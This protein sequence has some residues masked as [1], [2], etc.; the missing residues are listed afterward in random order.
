MRRFCSRGLG[1]VVA[2]ISFWGL[3]ACGGHKPAGQST[4]PAKVNLT[5]AGST[6]VQLGGF[7]NFV[8]SAQ[9]ATGTNVNTVFTFTSSDTSILNIAPNGA[10]CAGVWNASFTTCTPAGTGVVQVQASTRNVFSP[11]TYVFVHPQIDHVE[12]VGVLPDGLPIQEPCLSQGQA[13]T[14]EAHAFSQGT[15]ITSAVGP[16]TWAAKDVSVVGLVPKVNPA[17]NFATNQAVATANMPGLTQIY[18]TASGVASD[19][20]QQPNLVPSPPVIFDFF[21]TC[22]IQNIT[23]ELGTAGSRQTQFAVTKGTSE[24]AIAT[25][26]DVLGNSSLP[27]I[28]NGVVLSK[29][30]LT[31]TSSQPAVIQVAAACV[32]SCAISTPSPGAGAVTAACSPPSC[33]IGFPQVPAAFSPP[34][35]A[36]CATYVHSLLPQVTNCEAFIPTP[37]YATTAISGVAAGASTASNA[38][39]TSMGCALEPPATC[40]TGIYSFPTNRSAAGTATA[41]PTAPNSLMFT[42]AGDKVF[43]GSDFGAQWINP[44]NLGTQNG[45]FTSLGTV[46]GRIL[47]V[48][49]NGNLAVFSDTVH[50]PNQVYI[51]NISNAAAPTATGLAIAGA[52]TAAFSQDGLKTF[53][54]GFD[55]NGLPNLYVYSAEEALQTIPLP[56]QTSVNA[57]TFSTNGAFAYVVEPSLAGAGPA[58]T[59]YNTCDNQ[60]FTDTITG[61]HDIPLAAPPVAFKALPDGRHFLALETDG[62]FEYI[63]AS[64]TGIPVATLA[65]AATSVCPMLVGHTAPQKISFGQGT[66]QPIDFFTSADGTL[67]YLVARDRSSVLVYDFSTSAVNGI[68]LVGAGNP[69]PLSASM[70]VDGATILIAATDGMV[71]EVSTSNGGSDV[72]QATFPNLANYQNPFCTF[73]P[74]SGP[75]TFDYI[76]ARP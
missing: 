61:K 49:T 22:P 71:H 43:M 57:I 40:T 44:A 4:F 5:P 76:G 67:I 23:L 1:L 25:I 73:T 68:Q 56:P 62:T 8:A 32:E 50:T 75:C 28:T 51:V 60:V 19:S 39:A 45:A 59:V 34:S 14:I 21:E 26:T 47:A 74:A 11:P 64:I 36:A 12:V 13:M 9:N 6:S 37:V 63:T 7:I 17:Y 41:M 38:I 2:I 16:F 27:N 69:T 53:I 55:T 58:V 29:I 33:N 46:T 15:D 35:L 31:W 30:P 52:S 48:S 18:A 42:L 3:P 72:F 70:T 65:K 10:G 66:I 24:T 20:F 54:Y